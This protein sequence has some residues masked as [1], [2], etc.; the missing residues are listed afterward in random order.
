VDKS[1]MQDTNQFKTKTVRPGD[2]IFLNNGFMIFRGFNTQFENKNYQA[3]TGDISVAAELEVYNLE[4][5]MRKSNPVYIIRD[6][7]ER[8]ITD[9]I[10]ESGLMSRLVKILPEENA[11]KIEYKQPSAMDDYIIMKAIKFPFINV[12]WIG[13][14]LMVLGFGISLFKRFIAK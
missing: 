7:M 5:K 10:V 14:V 3:Q 9:T 4:G 1:K 8:S 12:L 11:A 2:S 6:R 13:T